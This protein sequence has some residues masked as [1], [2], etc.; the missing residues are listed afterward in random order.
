VLWLDRSA[1]QLID[2]LGAP[3][4]A[5]AWQ[6]YGD[7][8]LEAGDARGEW[9][10]LQRAGARPALVARADELERGMAQTGPACDP[11]FA[12]IDALITRGDAAPLVERALTGD[13]EQVALLFHCVHPD[14]LRAIGGDAIGE[15]MAA[16]IWRV[17][18]AVEARTLAVSHEY[19][20]MKSVG[21]MSFYI[22]GGWEI[23]IYNRVYAWH[24]VHELR[25]PRRSAIS[26]TCYHADH[27]PALDEVHAYEP[28]EPI[29]S[30]VYGFTSR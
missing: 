7:A 24:Y 30:E 28:R 23:E 2:L 1:S 17:L 26:L 13:V 29:L 20:P 15:R 10:A 19:D 5:P 6:V 21:Y 12:I 25:T 22:E 4:S 16:E 18:R 14:R 27:W 9:I 3:F 8:L 11:R